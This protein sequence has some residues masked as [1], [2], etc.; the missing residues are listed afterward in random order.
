MY[1]YIH[2]NKA[3]LIFHE[4]MQILTKITCEITHF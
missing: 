1:I 2:K 3:K 4:Q